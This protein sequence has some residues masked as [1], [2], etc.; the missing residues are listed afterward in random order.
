MGAKASHCLCDKD[1]V[2]IDVKNAFG[3]NDTYEYFQ[4]ELDYYKEEMCDSG[5]YM[6]C[7][8]CLCILY[9]SMYVCMYVQM[10]WNTLPL[11]SYGKNLKK[12]LHHQPL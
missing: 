7:M 9:V 12:I 6:Y 1:S 5:I 2:K 4:H 3:L 10:K 11:S 8:Y